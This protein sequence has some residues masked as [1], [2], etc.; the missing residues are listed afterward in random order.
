M[1]VG[2]LTVDTDV[3]VIGAGPGGY[4]AAIRAAQLGF[5]VTLIDQDKRLGGICLNHGCIPTKALIHASNFFSTLKELDAM[6]IHVKDYA[7][8]HAG[9]KAWKDSILQRLGDGIS[10]LCQKH[11]IE[12]INGIAGFTSST[13][14][15]IGGQS[16]VTAVN[17]K[18]AIIATG[19][20]PVEIPGFPFSHPLVMSSR[21]ALALT[22]V[23]QKLVII[24]G[25]YIGTEM[26]TVYGKLGSEVH[27]VEMA[28]RL[29]PTLDPEIVQVVARR[30]AKFNVT[31]HL[32]SAAKGLEEK[33]GRAVVTI[34]QDG[35]EQKIDADKVLV[36]VGRRPN[37]AS[38]GLEKTKVTLDKGFIRVD[39]Q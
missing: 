19:S 13:M 2:A 12:V 33:G 27:I 15:H 39:N 38:L 6:G 24:G 7:I 1:V 23:P 36:V 16:D 32:K 29:I 30:L 22:E 28:E 18:H 26:G 31:T 17:F 8:D 20:L 35:K 37:T 3:V 21:D 5:D 4:V 34:L 11:G 25:G 14:M 9:M 10:S